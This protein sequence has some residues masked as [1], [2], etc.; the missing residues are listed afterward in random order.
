MLWDQKVWRSTSYGLH[1]CCL[2]FCESK[3]V[4]ANC[5]Q[6]TLSTSHSQRDVRWR[7]S[8]KG[9]LS[10]WLLNEFGDIISLLLQLCYYFNWTIGAETKL[11]PHSTSVTF[12]ET[13]SWRNWAIILL[14]KGS[15]KGAC[16]AAAEFTSEFGFSC[17]L[18][19]LLFSPPQ[20]SHFQ[21]KLGFPQ[22]EI[23]NGY[24]CALERNLSHTH[25][26]THNHT[27]TEKNTQNKPVSISG[28]DSNK[29]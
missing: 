22:Q 7:L 8:Q 15:V 21:F 5:S 6:W 17:L 28:Y 24:N 14:R 26:H 25:T 4:L 27:V 19:L 23:F 20:L 18:L 13:A 9:W 3:N 10:W 29:T 11:S 16:V 2:F 1:L 12:T